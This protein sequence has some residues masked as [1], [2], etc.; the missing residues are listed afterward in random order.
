L[1]ARITFTLLLP[2]ET[3]TLPLASTAIPVGWS[4]PLPSVL[5]VV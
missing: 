4:N 5:T 1:G 3:N 2:S